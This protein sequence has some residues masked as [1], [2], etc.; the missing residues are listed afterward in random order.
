MGEGGQSAASQA[1]AESNAYASGFNPI[2]S[3]G[4]KSIDPAWIIGGV[5][6]VGLIYLIGKKI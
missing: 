4:K 3:N 1:A 6:L 5:A 2:F